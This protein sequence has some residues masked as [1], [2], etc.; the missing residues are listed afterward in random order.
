M[1]KPGRRYIGKQLIHIQADNSMT[2]TKNEVK[3]NS[4]NHTYHNN[5]R[6]VAT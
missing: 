4:K 2:K 1:N 3:T 6:T 5:K